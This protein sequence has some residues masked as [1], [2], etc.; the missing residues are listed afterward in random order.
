MGKTSNELDFFPANC[1]NKHNDTQQT[2]LISQPKKE[3]TNRASIQS[4]FIGAKGD[5]FKLRIWDENVRAK[6]NVLDLVS[7]LWV[8][9]ER[10]NSKVGENI[11]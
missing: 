7:L 1:G 10:G 9:G 3:T 2:K 5:F 8:E 11:S 4:M 6:S